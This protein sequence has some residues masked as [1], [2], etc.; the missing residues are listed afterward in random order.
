ME[1]LNV[2]YRPCRCKIRT[3]VSK[4]QS[5][6]SNQHPGVVLPYFPECL[7]AST[8]DYIGATILDLTAHS[9]LQ[10][11]YFLFFSVQNSNLSQKNSEYL[12]FLTELLPYFID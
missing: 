5:L 3:H 4:A 10:L 1:C 11:M 6:L 7:A 9:V 12:S 8:L 2:F